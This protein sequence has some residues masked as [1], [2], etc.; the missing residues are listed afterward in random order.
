LPRLASRLKPGGLA[1]LEMGSG[2]AGDLIKMVRE[3]TPNLNG[4]IHR[5]LAGHD[6]ILAL[7]FSG[8]SA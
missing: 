2:Q 3:L 1:L 4:Q 8:D 7:E 6:R 5:D